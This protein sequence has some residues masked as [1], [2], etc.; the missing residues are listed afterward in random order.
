MERTISNV[1]A[2]RILGHQAQTMDDTQVQE[3]LCSLK[4]LAREGVLY[5]GSKEYESRIKPKS[6]RKTASA[7]TTA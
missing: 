1:K 2:R 5:N 6:A 4:L 3:L 7:T